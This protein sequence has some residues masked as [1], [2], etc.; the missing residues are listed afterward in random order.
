MAKLRSSLLLGGPVWWMCLLAARSISTSTINYNS[1]SDC[2]VSNKDFGPPFNSTGTVSFN[3]GSGGHN[4]TKPWYLTVGLKDKRDPNAV[5]YKGTQTVNS[6]ISMPDEFLHSLDGGYTNLC[7]YRLGEQNTTAAEGNG[8]C[9]G[10]LSAACTKYI[11]TFRETMSF[12]NGKCPEFSPG[13]GCGDEIIASSAPINLTNTSSSCSTHGLP[14][15]VD[16]PENFTTRS[17]FGFGWL[18]GDRDINSLESYDL[19]VRQPNP[20]LLAFGLKQG[21]GQDK[22]NDTVYLDQLLCVTPDHIAA[23]SHDPKSSAAAPRFNEAVLLAIA[24]SIVYGM[25]ALM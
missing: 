13:Q 24:L 6:Y 3:L 12:S 18:Y 23:G 22:S 25:H 20:V 16:I 7:A 17:L 10:V 1:S 5:S 14:G 15:V 21:H 11:Q 4:G 8:S 2:N 9:N 19:H